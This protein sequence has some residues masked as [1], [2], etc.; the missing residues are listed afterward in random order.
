M[1]YGIIFLYMERAIVGNHLKDDFSGQ[2]GW[3][4]P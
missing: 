3:F 2:K 1:L 4:S